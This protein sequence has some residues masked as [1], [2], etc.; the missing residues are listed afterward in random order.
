MKQGWNWLET[1]TLRGVAALVCV[2]CGT[3]HVPA[4]LAQGGQADIAYPLAIACQTSAVK[5]DADP[6][7]ASKGDIAFELNLDDPQ[8]PKGPGRWKVTQSGVEHEVSFANAT[9][10][11]CAPDCPFTRGE[12]G[13]WQL[14]SPKPLALTQ[15]DD[16]TALIL[17]T[18]NPATLELKASSFRKK[19]LAGLER[20]D[21][22]IVG[23]N[24]PPAN[25]EAADE[26]SDAKAAGAGE[27][28]V[29]Q[30][31]PKP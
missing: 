8:K 24:S 11:S 16:G 27:Q 2:L 25:A 13:T 3:L 10:E 5:L 9:K 30:D 31:K 29:E 20:G 28:G 6:F 18:I 23:E 7:Q 26:S 21:C 19:E 14:W 4:V 12:D 15:L 1:A 17:V 22:K